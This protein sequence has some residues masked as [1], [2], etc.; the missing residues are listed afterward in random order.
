MPWRAR[1]LRLVVSDLLFPGGPEGAAGILSAQQ[2]RGVVLV[3]FCQA[4]ADPAWDG[5]IDFEEVENGHR[6]PRRVEPGLLKRYAAAY[7][8]HFTM[9]KESCRRQGVSLARVP[10]GVP[11]PQ[12]LQLEALPSG[13]VEPWA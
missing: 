8:R 3:P 13:A 4:E 10:S 6:H 12:S 11:F 2:G 1:S 5:N 9:W 7:A